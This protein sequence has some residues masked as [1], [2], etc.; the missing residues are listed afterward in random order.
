MKYEDIN[1]NSWTTS[2]SCTGISRSKIKTPLDDYFEIYEQKG[3]PWLHPDGQVFT[4][5]KI[6]PSPAEDVLHVHQKFPHIL[7][8]LNICYLH[9]IIAK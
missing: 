8:Y 1:E 2:I 5:N 6:V 7:S 9:K 3:M 4:T